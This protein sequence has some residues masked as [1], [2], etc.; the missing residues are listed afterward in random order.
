MSAP[1][2]VAGLQPTYLPESVVHLPILWGYLRCY[3]QQFPELGPGIY[4]WPAPLWRT[5]RV[6]EMLEETGDP[7]VLAV[8]SYVW[9]QRN[10]HRLARAVKERDPGCL[11]VYGGPNVPSQPSSYLADHPWIDLL[12]HG[13]GERPFA[14]ILREF[15]QA[16]PDW[17]KVSGVSFQRRGQQHFTEPSPRLESLDFPSPVLEGLMDPFLE[18]VRR[19]Q[20]YAVVIAGLETNR[21]CPYSCAFCDWGMATHSRVRRYPKDRIFKE[22]DWAASKGISVVWL[23][24]ANFG[25][26]PGDPDIVRHAAELKARTG[27][28][29]A[30][31]ALGFAK[32]NKD[33]TFEISQLI[34]DSVLDPYVDSVNFS[35]QTVSQATLEAVGRDNIPLQNYRDLADR[36]A[37]EGY[38]LHPDLILPLPGETLQSFKQGYADL[39]SWPHVERIQV[40]AATV[41]PNAPMAQPEYRER[42]QLRTRVAPLGEPLSPELGIAEERVEVVVSTSTM[43]EAEH[44]QGKLFVAFVRALELHRL[45]RQLRRYA[46]RLGG[47]PVHEFYD[48]LAASQLGGEG[49]LAPMLRAIQAEIASGLTGD[50]LVWPWDVAARDGTRLKYHKALALDV[51]T[52]PER[53]SSELRAFLLELLSQRRRPALDELLRYQA[54]FWVLPDFDPRDP[55]CYRFAYEH[56][57]PGFLERGEGDEPLARPTRVVYQP[58]PMWSQLGY[59]GGVDEWRKFVL[60]EHMPHLDFCCHGLEG[61]QVSYL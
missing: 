21:G 23:H 35:L 30:F 52:E 45:T 34:A 60:A 49:L 11:V 41:L 18:Q 43:S 42:Y 59:Q 39:A 2:L 38:S 15:R 36:Y 19:E 46:A 16:R 7:A 48:A 17:G 58:P 53:F 29:Q 25:L 1:V 5:R 27:F 13:E 26:F 32:N 24:D 31:Y 55:D 33:R 51:V 4:S 61:R 12:V 50:E 44:V 9:N 54:D 37:R 3:C 56:D 10:S 20:P 47:P 57:W 40:Y 14:G 28:P 8:S 6:E 22:L